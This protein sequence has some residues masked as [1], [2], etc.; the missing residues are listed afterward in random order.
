MIPGLLFV[1]GVVICGISGALVHELAHYLVWLLSDR[2]P[3]LDIAGLYVEPT[4][5]PN[6]IRI[7]DRIAALAPVL[8]GAC[9]LPFVIKAGQVAVWIG[10][11]VLTFGGARE[12]WEMAFSGFNALK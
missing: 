8:V 5:G 11:F 2:N 9:L 4:S 10:W 12:D 1:V 3:R 7:S 6:D